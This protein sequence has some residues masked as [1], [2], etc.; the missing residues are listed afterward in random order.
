MKRQLIFCCALPAFAVL[1]AGSSLQAQHGHRGG[2]HRGGGHRGIGH[3]G[4]HHY[5]VHANSRHVLYGYGNYSGNYYTQDN[6]YYYN[7]GVQNAPSQRIEYGGFSRVDELGHRLETLA[8]DYCLELHANYSR[9]PGFDDTYREAYEILEIAKYIHEEEHHGH[10]DEI[11]QEM[12]KLDDLFHHV[13][14]IVSGWQPDRQRH[15]HDN[16]PAKDQ[17]QQ[18]METV[19]HHLMNDVGVKPNAPQGGPPQQEHSHGG[20]AAHSSNLQ[21]SFKNLPGGF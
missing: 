19:I 12:K 18:Q 14:G 15:Q 17:I 10:R 11:A 6:G 1:I 16:I 7:S 8:N 5:R 3:G 2:G 21:P 9:N 4:G 13:G 20:G